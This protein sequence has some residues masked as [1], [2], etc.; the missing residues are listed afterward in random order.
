MGSKVIL[1]EIYHP[2]LSVCQSA[3]TDYLL[4][5]VCFC[6]E[7][8]EVGRYINSNF[9]T[10]LGAADLKGEGEVHDIFK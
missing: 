3:S 5:K 7:V 6:L 9:Q 10:F 2:N 4:F 1:T 8:F